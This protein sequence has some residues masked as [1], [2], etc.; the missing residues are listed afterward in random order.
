LTDLAESS[1]DLIVVNS[2]LQYLPREDFERLLDFCHPR[3][4]PAGRLLIGDVV[5]PDSDVVADTLALLRFAREGG[6][7]LAAIG[8]LARTFFSPYRHLRGALGFTTY[9]PDDI[10]QL[11]RAHGFDGR[12]AETN[13]G[14]NRRRMTFVAERRETSR[15]I[16]SARLPRS[17]GRNRPRCNGPIADS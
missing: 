4:A 9:A 6:F 1:L 5:R 10:L 7:F 16:R 13:I 8:G 11:L 2:L 14:H 12:Q 3:L 17:A 15:E